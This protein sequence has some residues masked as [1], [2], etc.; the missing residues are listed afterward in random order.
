M[1]RARGS[2][3]VR[4]SARDLLPMPRR[5]PAPL[6]EMPRSDARP[7]FLRQAPA[8]KPRRSRLQAAAFMPPAGRHCEPPSSKAMQ[9]SFLSLSEPVISLSLWS[10]RRVRCL[11]ILGL[12]RGARCFSVGSCACVFARHVRSLASNRRR[13]CD[14]EAVYRIVDGLHVCGASSTHQRVLRRC[15]CR[16][17]SA[18]SQ[19]EIE[20]WLLIETAQSDW[21]SRPGRMTDVRFRIHH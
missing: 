19:P 10:V 13:A 16:A 7:F 4:L 12:S 1:T 2:R 5:F 3:I 18:V 14:G 9:E 8:G 21:P 11:A 6:S 20:T 15:C 17:S